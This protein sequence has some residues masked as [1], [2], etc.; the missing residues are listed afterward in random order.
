M[1]SIYGTVIDVSTTNVGDFLAVD[2]LAA[3]AEIYVTDVSVFNEAGGQLLLGGLIYTYTGTNPDLGMIVLSTPLAADT[4]TDDR[5]ELYPPA[6][7]K[8]ALIDLGID[9][10]EAIQVTVP[11]ALSVVL[12]DGMR[13]DATREVALLEER[14]IGEI[15]LADITAHPA[16]ISQDVL[17]PELAAVTTDGMPPY[18]SPNAVVNP[19]I[20]ALHVHWLALVTEDPVTYEVYIST[21]SGFAPDVTTLVGSTMAT[22]FTIRSLPNDLLL[23]YDTDYYVRLIARDADG[24]ASPGDEGTAR[25]GKADQ[26]SISAEYIYGGIISASQITGGTFQGDMFIGGK[27]ATAETGGRIEIDPEGVRAYAPNETLTTN[28]G[29]DGANTFEGTVDASGGLTVAGGMSVQGIDNSLEIASELELASSSTDPTNAITVAQDWEMLTPFTYAADPTFD[30]ANITSI[31][32]VGSL[33]VCGYRDGSTYRVYRFSTDGSFHSLGADSIVDSAL[34]YKQ[35]TQIVAD[36]AVYSTY[37]VNKIAK[38]AIAAYLLSDDFTSEV[39]ATTWPTRINTTWDA[40]R[41]KITEG[42]FRTGYTRDVEDGYLSAKMARS[43]STADGQQMLMKFVRS[44]DVIDARIY[45]EGTQIKFDTGATGGDVQFRAA[46]ADDDQDAGTGPTVNKPGGTLVGDLLLATMIQD[47]DNTTAVPNNMTMPTCACTFPWVKIGS[48]GGSSSGFMSVWKH[49][50]LAGCSASWKITDASQS[51]DDCDC[52]AAILGFHD[53]DPTQTLTPT[54][55]QNTSAAT[56]FTAPSV[57]G[58]DGGMLICAYGRGDSANGTAQF[59]SYSGSQTERADHPTSVSTY[60]NLAIATE[61]L[62]AGGATGTRTAACSNSSASICWSM[63]IKPAGSGVAITYSTSTHA[64]WRI[65]EAGNTFYFDTSADGVT[66][67]QRHSATHTLSDAQMAAVGFEF[68]NT[69]VGLA[70][71]TVH[72]DEVRH[73]VTSD[74]LLVSLPVSSAPGFTIGNDGTNVL[75]AWHDTAIDKGVIYE[76]NPTTLAVITTVN[77]GVHSFWAGAQQTLVGVLKGTF[78]IGSTRYFLKALGNGATGNGDWWPF[79]TTGAIQ[80]NDGFGPDGGGS[81][82]IVWDGTHFLGLGTNGRLYRHTNIEKTNAV[83]PVTY[84]AAYTW[85][86]SNATGGTHESTVGLSRITFQLKKRARLTLTAPTIPS[87]GT[88][89]PNSVR[90]YL[91]LTSTTTKLEVT[92]GVGVRDAI[93]NTLAGTGT[94]PPATNDFPAAT[95]AKI[96]NPDSTLIIS[97]DGSI[98]ADKLTVD[99]FHEPSPVKVSVTAS[100]TIAPTTTATLIPGLTLTFTPPSTAAVYL[101]LGSMDISAT[102]AAE[103]IPFASLYVDSTAQPGDMTYRSELQ[104]GRTTVHQHWIVS[105]LSVASHTLQLR[106]AGTAG[107]TGYTV[108]TNSKMTI[109]LLSY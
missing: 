5:V 57:T 70:A 36:G 91:G 16:T 80:P 86:D 8:K 29:I 43:G 50:A 46:A 21:A 41:A 93:L 49:T 95:P 83:N 59:S 51:G 30:A 107:V 74:P 82:A 31:A 67:T 63:V 17:P 98:V 40:G 78:D 35:S 52:A 7:V 73:G 108:H 25:I 26:E 2:A 19:M 62:S 77:T 76:L 12:D 55:Q 68:K 44:G 38:H 90:F 27:F 94:A 60:V 87:G 1:S 101:V 34:N 96:R 11:H 53:W 75:V 4:F 61:P 72:V 28:L 69:Y 89:D 104:T 18:A 10:G 71:Q 48:G 88:D 20:G 84:W 100:T 54:F 9:E 99:E 92:T 39:N 37:G 79:N 109:I 47:R 15:Y 58:Y 105:S 56:I 24:A 85:Y 81:K 13:E 103:A 33:W 22:S 65:R 45:T 23:A 66:W 42:L 14:N 106:V 3:A 102:A 64:Y 6:P 32:K 97:G